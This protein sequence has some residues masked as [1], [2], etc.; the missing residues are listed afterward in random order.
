MANESYW[1]GCLSA[2]TCSALWFCW[3]CNATQHDKC[4]HQRPRTVWKPPSPSQACS[5]VPTASPGSDVLQK[6]FKKPHRVNSAPKS[7][8][9]WAD[10]ARVFGSWWQSRFKTSSSKGHNY[11]QVHSTASDAYTRRESKQVPGKG[12]QLMRTPQREWEKERGRRK[13]RKIRRL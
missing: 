5:L 2:V 10:L 9:K 7:K 6:C 12:T 13:S 3:W 11:K 1:H 4:L 8:Q